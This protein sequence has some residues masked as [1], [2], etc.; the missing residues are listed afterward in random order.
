[1]MGG[2]QYGWKQVNRT[3]LCGFL[4]KKKCQLPVNGGE[5]VWIVARY[6]GHHNQCLAMTAEAVTVGT[7]SSSDYVIC[8]PNMRHFGK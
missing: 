7:V 6:L 5:L 1:M 2:Q 3:A 4:H 8:C